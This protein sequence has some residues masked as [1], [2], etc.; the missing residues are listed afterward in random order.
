VVEMWYTFKIKQVINSSAKVE[1]YWTQISVFARW[2]VQN[3][4]G[5][6]LCLDCPAPALEDL[7]RNLVL[8]KISSSTCHVRFLET[9][10]DLY[11]YSV[12]S[13]RDYVRGLE[14]DRDR[15]QG[16]T[17]NF[18]HLHDMARHL[19]HSNETLQVAIETIQSIRARCT[20]MKESNFDD[21]TYAL[22]K[23]LKA[24][25]CRSESLRERLQNE[26]NLAF[27][28][29]AQRESRIMVG[30]GND[31]RKDSNTMSFIA[32]VGLVY[33]P[34][35]FISGLFGTNFFNVTGEPGQE[36]WLISNN[37][38][39]YWALTIPITFVTIFSWVLAFHGKDLRE[40]TMARIRRSRIFGKES[41]VFSF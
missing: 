23:E 16:F 31:S 18:V 1:Y 5:L 40:R 11:N 36:K 8:R 20:H 4:M 39:L 12:W 14:R 37:F 38:W 15:E 25:K 17:P 35:T 33:L 2:N 26:I 21:Q 10:R 32:V 7:K 27:N 9:V 22:Q 13:L 28:L 6:I 19:I 3:S 34:G 30:L 41:V 24:I 29:V